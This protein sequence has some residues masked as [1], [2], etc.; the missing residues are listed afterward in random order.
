[1]TTPLQLPPKPPM[2]SLMKSLLI[3]LVLLGAL[4]SHAQQADQDAAPEEIVDRLETVLIE[5]MRAGESLSFDDRFEKLRPLV[6]D[7]MAV[8][9]MG[10]YLFGRDWAAFDEQ[11]RERFKQAF[12][13]LSAATYAGQFKEF[14]GER[15]DPVE[16]QRQGEDRVV[17]KRR[18][19]TGSGEKVA[20]DY[21]MTH[22]DDGWQIV[23]II[24]DGVSDLAVKRS[25][26]RR[27][28]EDQDFEAVISR[29]QDSAES[30]RSD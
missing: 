19:T 7:I 24:T 8:E 13:D 3:A 1:M 2:K 9:R 11:Q 10:R 12:L 5:N 21:L 26:Y 6:A 4:S 14:G 25:Q 20:F 15:F 27:L 28:L 18:L 16:V 30:Q 17:V 22:S 23:T 29:I